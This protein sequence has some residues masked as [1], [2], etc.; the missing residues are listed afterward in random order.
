MDVEPSVLGASTD[1]KYLRRVRILIENVSTSNQITII[2]IT[3]YFQMNISAIGFTPLVNTISRPHDHNEYL[4][5]DTYLDGIRTYV[6][7]I[8]S[9]GNS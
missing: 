4:N 9:L 3:I 5:A 2:T 1:L 8:S 6:K 7:I